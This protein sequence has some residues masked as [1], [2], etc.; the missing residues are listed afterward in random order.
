MSQFCEDENGAL[1]YNRI[2]NG[3]G[4]GNGNHGHT[5]DSHGSGHDNAHYNGFGNNGY[6]ISGNGNNGHGNSGYDNY[7]EEVQRRTNTQTHI[8]GRGD[9]FALPI[10]AGPLPAKVCSM[11]LMCMSTIR[12]THLT[13]S[14][15]SSEP[16]S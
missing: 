10:N 12:K 13:S 15:V 8:R 1:V 7:Q 14:P 16:V 6:G 5:G 2:T 4:Y 11:L 9:N 3:N